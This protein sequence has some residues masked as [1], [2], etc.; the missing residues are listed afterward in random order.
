M[1]NRLTPQIVGTN[2]HQQVIVPSGLGNSQPGDFFLIPVKHQFNLGPIR[3]PP[4]IPQVSGSPPLSALP[5]DN[6][7]SAFPPNFSA[8]GG[9]KRVYYHGGF[10]PVIYNNGTFHENRM[11]DPTTPPPGFR[12]PFPFNANESIPFQGTFKPGKPDFSGFTLPKHHVYQPRPEHQVLPIPITPQLVVR[13]S[14]QFSEDHAHQAV[15]SRDKIPIA[16]PGSGATSLTTESVDNSPDPIPEPPKEDSFIESYAGDNK[17]EDRE[18]SQYTPYS[19]PNQG[20]SSAHLETESSTQEDPAEEFERGT[21][22]EPTEENSSVHTQ[23]STSVSSEETLLLN[24]FAPS[25]EEANKTDYSI[26]SHVMSLIAGQ[27]Q[28]QH[29]EF[30]VNSRVIREAKD[31]EEGHDGHDHDKHKHKKDDKDKDKDSK[32]KSNKKDKKKGKNS[33]TTT[34]LS[35]GMIAAL[36]LT[37]LF[38]SK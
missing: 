23:T 10:V 18:Q 13:P 6:S 7:R 16:I 31:H 35:S 1:I 22:V 9:N 32:N 33:A 37:V 12:R 26:L 4:A 17:E 24:P 21:L 14:S 11:P 30:K 38:S 5:Q 36:L 2:Q 25:K 34:N 8:L 28:P 20:E 27:S 29:Q 15:S 3:P 19:V